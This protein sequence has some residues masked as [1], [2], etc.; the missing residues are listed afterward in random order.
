M[1]SQDIGDAKLWR[2]FFISRTVCP[3]RGNEVMARIEIQEVSNKVHIHFLIL[4]TLQWFVRCM[5]PI[6]SVCQLWVKVIAPPT[7][8][9]KCHFQ[10]ALNSASFTQFASNFTRIMSKHGRCETVKGILISKILLPW[11]RVKPQY[12]FL[13]ILRH[14]RCLEFHKTQHT[15]QY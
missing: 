2:D 1:W 9:R 11:Q 3:W 13:V 15:H 8:S 7:G 10:N 6:A 14:L 5:K 12:S 4:I